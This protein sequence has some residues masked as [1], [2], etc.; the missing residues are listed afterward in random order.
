MFA[1]SFGMAILPMKD[2]VHL[3]MITSR[4]TSSTLRP[5]LCAIRRT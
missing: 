5:E 3:F 2:V 1:T 4:S